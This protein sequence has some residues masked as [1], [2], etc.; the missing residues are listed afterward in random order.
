[1]P[2]SDDLLNAALEN[3][4]H[5]LRMYRLFEEKKPVMLYDIQE[6]RIYAYP[7]RE[8]KAE[9]SERSQASLQEQ[10]EE[11]IRENKVVVFVRDNDQRKLVSFSLDLA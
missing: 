9:L 8:F 1:M 3:W 4:E 10:Y 5:I 6:E 2:E 11:A 7:Y